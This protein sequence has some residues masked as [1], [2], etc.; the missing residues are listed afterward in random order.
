VF[1]TLTVREN[2]RA[3]CWLSRRHRRAVAAQV[4]AAFD[5]FPVLRDRAGDPAGDLSGGQQQMLALAMAL[6][7]TPKVLL[8]DELSLGLAPAVVADLIPAIRRVQQQGTAVVLVEQSVQV[9][10]QVAETAVFLERGEVRYRGPTAELLQRPD[11]LRSVFLGTPDR[12]TATPAPHPARRAAEP[13]RAA[14]GAPKAVLACAGLG[15]SFGGI[16]AVDDVSFALAP[17]ERLGLIGA[18]GAG[19]TTLF[20]LLSGHTQPDSGRVLLAGTDVTRMSAAGRGAR[21]LGRSFQDARL[22]PSMTVAETI[23]V[24]ADRWIDVRDPMSAALRLPNA[25]AAELRVRRRVHELTELLGLGLVRSRF[26][27]ELS[28]GTRR[29][30]DL[31]CVLAHRPRVVL[32]DEPSAGLAQREVEA[33]GPL[34]QTVGAETGAAMVVIEHDMNLLAAVADRWL[35]LEGGRVLLDGPAADVQRDARVVA[36]YMGTTTATIERSDRAPGAPTRETVR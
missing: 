15:V 23:A 20:D 2:L 1:P 17:G 4:E 3:A 24:A 12:N 36:S 7:G 31:A 6:A 8:V 22:F 32:L 9:A 29:V 14:S 5:L 35:A 21:G 25:Y 10:L 34:L 28:T 33:L 30:V 26:V 16:R 18:N 27:R 19:K 11:L 13:R